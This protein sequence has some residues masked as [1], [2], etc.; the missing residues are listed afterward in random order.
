MSVYDQYLKNYYGYGFII[1]LG[2]TVIFTIMI[3]QIIYIYGIAI[4]IYPAIIL[5][6]FGI[7]MTSTTKGEQDA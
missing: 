1:I 2:I 3:Q 5:T 6:I 4:F 7:I